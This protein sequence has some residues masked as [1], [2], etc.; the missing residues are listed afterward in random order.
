LNVLVYN[1]GLCL[2]YASIKEVASPKSIRVI[3][4][5]YCSEGGRHGAF[6]TSMFSSF[7]S[8]WQNPDSCI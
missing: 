8:L 4:S 7:K 6:P 2:P 1:L 3:R 5:S